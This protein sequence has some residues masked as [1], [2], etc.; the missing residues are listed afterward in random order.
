[1]QFSLYTAVPAL[2]LDYGCREY[3]IFANSIEEA[4]DK[5][6]EWLTNRI[7][8][9]RYTLAEVKMGSGDKVKHATVYYEPST[10]EVTFARHVKV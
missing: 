8:D 2:P 7:D 6:V 3:P 1:M 4:I 5:S 10:Q 9:A